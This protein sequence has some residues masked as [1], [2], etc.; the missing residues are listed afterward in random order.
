[1]S[2]VT[3][4]R[5][6]ATQ[7]GAKKVMPWEAGRERCGT[8]NELDHVHLETASDHAIDPDHLLAGSSGCKHM[9]PFR[10]HTFLACSYAPCL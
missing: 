5:E 4:H 10:S 2:G 3:T 8:F 7:P 9:Y 6:Y 1:M